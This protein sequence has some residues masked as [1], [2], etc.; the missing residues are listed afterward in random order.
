MLLSLSIMVNSQE[1]YQQTTLE[2]NEVFDENKSY[3]CQATASIELHPGFDYHP[4]VNNEMLLDVDRYSVYPPSDGIYGGNTDDE[5][6]VVGS[7]P[8]MFDVGVMGASTYSIDIKL[9]Q[10]LGT[11]IPKLSI[12]YNN[13]S[14]NGLLGWSWDLWGLS[15]IER[16]GQTDFHDGRFTNVDFVNDRYIVDGQRMMPIGKNEYKTEIDN[17]DRIVAY[18]VT[19]NSPDYFVIWKSDGTIWEY[20]TTADSKV[21]PQGKNT[22]ALK[23]LLSKITDRDGNA[24]TYNYYENNATGESY[25]ENIY[26]SLNEKASV[27]PAYRIAFKYD[28]RSDESIGYIHESKVTDNKI[29]NKIEVFNNY[30]GRKII[31][32]ALEY[33]GPGYYNGCYYIHHRL[34]SIH[35]TINGKKVNPTRIIWNSKDKWATENACGFKKYE[36][37]KKIFNRASFVGDFNGDGFSDVLLLPYKVQ[38]TYTSDV[39]GEIYLNNGDGT[40]SDTPLTKCA[41]NK[42]LDWIYVY[43]INGDGVDDI[44]PYEIHYDATG[45]FEAVK[46]SMLIM[47]G[48]RFVNKKT[49]EYDKVVTLLPGNYIDKNNCVLLVVDA[50]DGSKNKN[51]ARCVYFK[52]G[53][54]VCAD[55]QNSDAIN[56]KNIN[57][58]AMDISGDGISELLT[59][60]ENGYRIYAVKNEVSLRLAATNVGTYFSSKVYPFPN[61]YNG[62][63]KIDL[64]YYDPARF[65]NVA[66]STGVGFLPPKQCMKNNLLKNV[67]LNAKDKYRYSL[68]EMQKPSVTIRTADF[69]GD[70][71]A[72]V[73]VFNNSAGNYYLEVG[74]SPYEETQT[75]YSFRHYSRYYMPINYSH[76]TI[77]L[78]RFLPQENVSILSGLPARYANASKAC[79]VSMIPNSA[80]YSVEKIVDGMG[81]S[82]EFLYDYLMAAAK[83][84]DGFYTCS[85]TVNS[86]NVEMKSVPLLA[87][88]EFKTY[89]INGKAVVK[90]YS[91]HNALVHKECRGFLGF[92]NVTVRSYVDGNLMNRQ[93]QEFDLEIL[94]S[95]CIPLLT[96]ENLFYGEHH[97]IKE[98]YY[99]YRKYTCAQNAK[100]ISPML[101]QDR[102][103]VFDVDRRNVVLKNIVSRN[104]YETDIASEMSYNNIVQ[105]KKTHK[106]YGDAKS[107][108]LEKSQYIEEMTMFYG[109]DIANWIINR[110]VKIIKS[111]SDNM[112]AAVGD[113]RLMEYDRANPLRVI[114]E[115]MIPNIQANEKDSLTLVVRYKYDKVGNVVEQA[116][117]SPSL[118]KEKVL[119]SEYGENYKY[120]YKTKSIDEIDREVVCK[121]D[122]DFGVMTS[123][124]DYNGF[125]TRIEKDAFG[126]TDVL[127]MPDG[128]EKVKVLRWSAKN[129]YAPENSSY[130]SWEKS[131]GSSET[132]VF[133][134]KSGAELRSVTFDING[135]A[136]IVDKCYDDFGNIRLESYPYYENED[137][138]FVSNVYDAHN[139][140][141]EKIY[142]DGAKVSYIYNGNDLLIDYVSRDAV[143]RH[144]KESYNIMGWLVNV[145]DEGGNEI[146]YEYYSDGKLRAA[147]IGDNRNTRISVTYDNRRNKSTIYDPNYG[148]MS[149]KYDALGNVK[150]ISNA[151]YVVEMDYDVL[152][153]IMTRKES[154]LRYNKRRLVRWEYMCDNGYNGLL[155]LITSTGGYQIEYV[156]DDKLRPAYT[157]ETVRGN[158][159]K[160]TYSYDEANRVSSVSYP[161]GFCMLKKYS[162]SGYEKMICDAETEDVLWRT[163]KT[164][165]NGY[166]TECYLGNGL[167]TRYAY[168][169]YNDMLENIVTLNEDA[170]LQ[171]L[172]YKYDGMGNLVSRYDRVG[173]NSEEFV[174]DSY[175]RLTMIILNGEIEGKMNYSNSGNL[176][177]KEIDGVKVMFDAIYAIDKPNAILSFKSED[178]EMSERLRQDI[179]YSTYDNAI[180]VKGDNKSL[181]MDYDYDNN[182]VFMQYNVDGKVKNKIYVGN[183]EYVEEDGKKKVLTYIEG[184]AGIFAVHV[185]DGEER[186]NYIHKDNLD[187]WNIITG[188]DGEI[189][190]KLSFDAW[191]NMRDPERWNEDVQHVSMLFDRGFTG[192]EHLWDFGLINMNGRLYDPLLS[193]MLSPDNNIQMPKSSQNFNRY[194]YCLNNPLKYYDP[195][196]EWVESIAFGVAGGAANLVLNAKNIDSF[197]E[198]ALLFGVGFVK[199]FLWQYTMPYSWLLQVGV[200]TVAGGLVYGANRMVGIGDGSFEF[201]GDDWNSVKSASHYGLG[202]GLVKG[203]MYTYIQE[204]TATQFGESFFESSY[205]RELSHGLTSLVAH[206]AGCWFSGQPFLTTMRFQDVG[207]DLKMLCF[208]ARRMLSSYIEGLGFGEEALGKRAQEIKDSI[209]GDLL[210]EIPDT[211]D[212]EYEC[213]LS[214]VFVEDF[215]LYVV[216]NI[217][218]MIPGEWL[219][220]YPKPYLEEVITFP[221]SYSL[222]KTLFFNK[223]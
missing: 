154:D 190:Q 52:K 75:S 34:S 41:F 151:Q 188:E 13:Q 182:R 113:V 98:H 129:R 80:F 51:L 218:Q 214:G 8:G 69:D 81:N 173:Y 133:Y 104:T 164:N 9:P 44:V 110:P 186:I 138:L 137:K 162:N 131:M 40:F 65:W 46:F 93:K 203:F 123:T 71:S 136:V 83:R 36:L 219:K 132:M 115:T 126:V 125:I 12:G 103:T 197:G 42:N 11:M 166:V 48:G 119:K 141:V 159:Y 20:G 124:I 66:I 148:Q 145:I 183:C 176:M 211:P 27:K 31:E 43:D 45:V 90:K 91:Y 120:R 168:N 223:Q 222:F 194:S 128:M 116:I 209:L 177:G 179:E 37:D 180:A 39:E 79:I 64:L 139:R 97:L 58:I 29:L 205:Y 130:Y 61:D 207:F 49:Y 99:E 210:S 105:L 198:A 156:Y 2:L 82:M 175:D 95:Y 7:I 67:R 163:E 169:P 171:D 150:R 117:S 158:R 127:R 24:I 155:R 112:S 157:I 76:Q 189:L 54:L 191:G 23:W 15:S 221:F 32:Y 22:V 118:K 184:P 109:N 200:G 102:E 111:V 144:K 88:K 35:L 18:N 10:A 86:Y 149:Y 165:S 26:Y 59:L 114:K 5:T 85:N 172:S 101:I 60:E 204:P 208:I 72:D 3:L 47:S 1:I 16:V 30:S 53:E 56:G 6:C 92:E 108:G 68:K 57:C 55:L 216:G 213:K 217:Y 170:V 193:R 74:F 181:L 202:S 195:T 201:S 78:G 187:S 140:M 161:S 17:F 215:R 147:Q 87:L 84:N 143:K 107:L 62:D 212:F 174:Y 38:E 152:G 121:Y 142:P 199:G 220:C 135:K 89:N 73:G 153:R 70:G 196:G 122:G 50:Y 167:R 77:Q 96:S 28:E 33:D 14:A 19:N 106:G 4:T 134:H 206:G 94:G 63:G 25:V 160:T 178:D 192:H 146:K 100:V 21:E 185:N